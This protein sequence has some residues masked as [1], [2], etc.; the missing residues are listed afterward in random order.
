MPVWDLELAKDQLRA[1][2]WTTS[3]YDY[4]SSVT[5]MVDSLGWRT[6]KR[7]GQMRVFVFFSKLFTCEAVSLPEY[8]QP[9]TSRVKDN[10][11]Y[12]HSL[13]FHQLYTPM[14]F[15]KYAF[16]P[17]AIYCPVEFPI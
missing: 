7:N 4:A 12:C 5:A 14:D 10:L 13:V 8:I 16:F 11:H 17:L 6:W 1:A 9:A 3:N 15:Y 2:S